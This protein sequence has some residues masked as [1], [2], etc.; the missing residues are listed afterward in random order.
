MRYLQLLLN[1]HSMDNFNEQEILNLA[2]HYATTNEFD[3]LKLF[4]EKGVCNIKNVCSEI[5]QKAL[6]NNNRAIMAIIK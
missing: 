1:Q 5:Y 6:L 2:I 4:V 3:A